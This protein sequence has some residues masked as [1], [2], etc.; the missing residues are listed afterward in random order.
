MKSAEK[1]Y[2][3]VSMWGEKAEK[4]IE[5]GGNVIVKTS[6]SILFFEKCL[7]SSVFRLQKLSEGSGCGAYR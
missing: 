1:Y 5:V 7:L 6:N 2:I 4:V 3:I